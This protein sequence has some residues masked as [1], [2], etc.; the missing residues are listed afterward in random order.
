MS[1][2]CQLRVGD[3]SVACQQVSEIDSADPTGAKPDKCEGAIA[4]EDVEF[5]YP[6]RTDVPVSWD[7]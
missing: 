3:V 5:V 1:V 6:T 2:T 7:L 4:F